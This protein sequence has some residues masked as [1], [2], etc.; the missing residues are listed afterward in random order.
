MTGP[1]KISRRP[2]RTA[3]RYDV[4]DGEMLTVREIATILGT[5]VGTVRSRIT[6]GWTGESLLLPPGDRRGKSK[7]RS[8]NTVVAYV[9]ALRFG[10]RLPTTKEIMETYPMAE[11]TA[12]WW[13]HTI[14]AA[15]ER[16]NSPKRTRR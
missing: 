1:N 4:G 8:Q 15:L 6:K 13:R 12:H 16:H 9:L 3:K 11:S 10:A 5:S 7:P 2:P 14:R